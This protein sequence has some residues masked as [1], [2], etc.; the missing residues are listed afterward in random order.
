MVLDSTP[1]GM[2]A[3][4]DGLDHDGAPPHRAIDLATVGRVNDLA[5]GYARPRLERAI[6]ALP[7]AVLTY[8]APQE[9]EAASVVMAFDVGADTAVWFVATTPQRRGQSLATG[10]L[11]RVLSD[12]HQRGQRTASLQASKAGAPIYERLGFMQAGTLHLYEERFR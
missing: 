9:G 10:N 6:A 3:E 4:L 11:R 2:V 5:Y 12:A 1:L 8:A 7:P